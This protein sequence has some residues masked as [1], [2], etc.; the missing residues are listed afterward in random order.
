[1]IETNIKMKLKSTYFFIICVLM[2]SIYSCKK[3]TTAPCI[4]LTLLENNWTN[5]SIVEQSYNSSNVITGTS[6]VY[7]TG[8]FTLNSNGSYNVV[9]DGVPLN[10]VWEISKANCDL[11]LDVN[12]SS[13]RYFTVKK[14]T[15]DSL[16]ISRTD[17]TN[18]IIYTQ[19]YSK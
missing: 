6:V 11:V 13:Q 7:P 10:G 2:L 12:T 3:H 17:S 18:M 19:H 1:L 9:S 14:L 15:T 16:V 5:A 8:T 4:D